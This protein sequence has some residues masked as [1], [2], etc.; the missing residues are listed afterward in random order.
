VRCVGGGRRLSNLHLFKQ[1]DV[2][3]R[4]ARHAEREAM[5]ERRRLALLRPESR[6]EWE[7]A[8]REPEP[9]TSAR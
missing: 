5:R 1:W 7:R 8:M 6:A 2:E 9:E 3:R 4:D